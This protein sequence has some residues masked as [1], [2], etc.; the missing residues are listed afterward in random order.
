[1]SQPIG[2]VYMAGL[3]WSRHK[4]REQSH[5]LDY[6]LICREHFWMLLIDCAAA[7]GVIICPTCVDRTTVLDAECMIHMRGILAERG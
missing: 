6:C 3:V 2:C 4:Q 7:D 1:M 5:V